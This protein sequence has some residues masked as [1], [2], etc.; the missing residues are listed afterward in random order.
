MSFFVWII[1]GLLAGAVSGWLVA[2]RSARGCLPNIVVGVLGG[3]L[4]LW[5][6]DQTNVGP[7]SG[8]VA[9]LVV[10]IIG[11]VIIRFVLESF[12]RRRT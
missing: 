7:V 8:F 11:A 2:G 10:A 12:G 4:G 6:A 9:T 3:L 1:I 5:L